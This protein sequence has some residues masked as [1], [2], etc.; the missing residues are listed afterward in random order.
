MSE[1]KRPGQG[2]SAVPEFTQTDFAVHDGSNAGR[3]IS[4]LGTGNNTAEATP[5]AIQR[6][7][8]MLSSIRGDADG[9]AA[10]VTPVQRNLFTRLMA[11]G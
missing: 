10:V 8:G 1:P 4:D 3:Q 2:R 5:E 7:M 9:G 6:L 11:A